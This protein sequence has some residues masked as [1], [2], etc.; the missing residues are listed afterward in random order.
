MSAASRTSRIAALNDALRSRAGLVTPAG[1][2]L[3][4][5]L[6]IITRG[7]IELPYARQLEILARVRCFDDFTADND[8]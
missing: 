4:K 2:G 7:V 8:P 6:V 5:G 3:P 1:N